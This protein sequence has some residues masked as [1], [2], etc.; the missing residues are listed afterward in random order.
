MT[1]LN[2]IFS[3]DTMKTIY[4]QALLKAAALICLQMKKDANEDS[5]SSE[6]I[7][8]LNLCAL[9]PKKNWCENRQNNS[10]LQDMKKT[11]NRD[12]EMS[13]DTAVAQQLI[14][15]H[16]LTSHDTERMAYRSMNTAELTQTI[17]AKKSQDKLA[18]KVQQRLA[19]FRDSAPLDAESKDNSTDSWPESHMWKID[20]ENC[21][22][23]ADHLYVTADT[24]LCTEIIRR[25]HD[26]EFAEHFEYKQTVELTQCSYNWSGSSKDIKVYCRHCILCQKDK[27]RRHKLYELLKS[28]STPTRVWGS[29][30]MNFITDLSSSK[31]YN[32]A[33]YNTVLITVNRLTKMTHY[34]AMRKNI[35]VFTLTEL[36]LYKHVRLHE[37][38]NNLI[39]NWETVFTSKYWS[40]FCFHLHAQ[41]NLITVFH[42]QMN[43]QTECQNQTL[44]TYIRMF[45]NNEQDDWALLLPMTEFVYNNSIH[46]VTEY[47]PF[48]AATGRNSKMGIDLLSHEGQAI[49][50]TELA[51]KLDSLHEDVK[52]QL[53]QANEKYAEFYNKKHIQKEFNVGCCVWLNTCNISTKWLSKKLQNKHLEPYTIM[54]KMSAQI[55]QLDISKW[56]KIYNVFNV[57]LLKLVISSNTTEMEIDEL[58]KKDQEWEIQ[59]L[60]NSCIVNSMLHYLIYWQG[61]LKKE[62]TWESAENL[63]HMKSLVKQFHIFNPMKPDKWMRK[64][65]SINTKKEKKANACSVSLHKQSTNWWLRVN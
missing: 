23:Y 9:L 11:L 22:L 65:I 40:F 54:K 2:R 35:D 4:D 31:G 60:L 17:L 1:S 58:L 47:T 18:K 53:L 13:A 28:L 62:V 21:L 56:Q 34:T 45:D 51:E 20:D 33:V 50:A 42:P 64:K 16:E 46:N 15:S 48:F 8:N 36:F 3:E 41:Q 49:Q 59:T 44:E 7:Q 38:L 37:I 30:T 29:V 12:Q 25:Y 61:F 26:D 6:K 27:A 19:I 63:H 32:R 52:L 5:D 10:S 14:S 24:S 57:Q 55:Y 43:D 39:M